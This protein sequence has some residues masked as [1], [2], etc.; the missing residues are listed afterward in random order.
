MEPD[1]FVRQRALSGFAAQGQAA[2]SSARIAIVGVG[3]LGCPAAQYLAA[4]G[5]GALTL[6]DS[7]SVTITNLHRQVLFGPDDVGRRKVVA[8]AEAL[9]TRTPWAAVTAVDARL[10]DANAADVLAGHDVILDATDT[11]TSRRVIARA[12]A[13]A[14]TPLVWGAVLGWHGQLTVFDASIGLAD[15]FP[16]DPPLEF[17]ACEDA[18]VLGTLCGQIGSAMATEAI[19]LVTG[20]GTPLVGTLSLLDARSGRWRDVPVSRR[21]H[22]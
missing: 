22:A 1:P 8:A 12:A 10:T 18:S 19:K 21:T 4:A 13:A 15:V 14:K 7:D 11:F 17:D 2:L 6:V 5:V 16:Q 3:G 9:G 20:A